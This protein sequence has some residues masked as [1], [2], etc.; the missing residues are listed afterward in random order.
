MGTVVESIID[1]R[2]EQGDFA[3]AAAV[4]EARS[5][6]ERAWKTSAGSVNESYVAC[7]ALTF[8][9]VSSAPAAPNECSPIVLPSVSVTMA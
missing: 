8:F 9:S 7:A 3:E 6:R 4:K 1:A 2:N 5:G